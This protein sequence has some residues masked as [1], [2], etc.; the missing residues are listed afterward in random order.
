MGAKNTTK[1]QKMDEETEFSN[2]TIGFTWHVN[3]CVKWS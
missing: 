1:D 3:K 2:D